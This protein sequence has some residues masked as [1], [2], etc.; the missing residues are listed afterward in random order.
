[1]TAQPMENAEL[2]ARHGEHPSRRPARIAQRRRA[3]GSTTA[4]QPRACRI[5]G[6]EPLPHWRLCGTCWAERRGFPG[7]PETHGQETSGVGEQL[8]FDESGAR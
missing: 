5:C 4:L 7:V 6:G 3:T 2:A 1:M 8:T